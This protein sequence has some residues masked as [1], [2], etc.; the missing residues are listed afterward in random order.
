MLPWQ[1]EIFHLL[2]NITLVQERKSFHFIKFVLIFYYLKEL[3]LLIESTYHTWP[4]FEPL[5]YKLAKF[6]DIDIKDQ[7]NNKKKIVLGLAVLCI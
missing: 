1:Q 7:K 3:A 4:K 2:E 5:Y 6:Q